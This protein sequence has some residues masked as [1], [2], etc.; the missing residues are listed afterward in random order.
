[1]NLL[2]GKEKVLC[3]NS[4]KNDMTSRT[5]DFIQKICYRRTASVDMTRYGFIS[6]SK[7]HPVNLLLKPLRQQLEK[8]CAKVV[9]GPRK[10]SPVK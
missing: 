5:R 2:K 6:D 8:I 9:H 10:P 7:I 4:Q 3:S 1:M